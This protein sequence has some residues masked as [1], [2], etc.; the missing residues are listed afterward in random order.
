MLCSEGVG[1]KLIGKNVR[2]NFAQIPNNAEPRQ[3][4]QRVI[5]DVNLPPEKALPCRRHVVMVIVVPAFAE[6]HEREQPIVL[7]GVGG[8]VASRTE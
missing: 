6:R 4:F 7:A 5:S 1:V 8:V 2:R 3:D